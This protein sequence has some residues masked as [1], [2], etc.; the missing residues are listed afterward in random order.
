[1]GLDFDFN[2]VVSAIV[3]CVKPISIRELYAQLLSI[4][5][6]WELTQGGHQASANVARQGRG[7]GLGLSGR[8]G[9][10]RGHGRRRGGGGRGG[11]YSGSNSSGKKEKIPCQVC[12]KV[13]HLALDCWH[14]FDE[15]YTF[16][17]KSAST[18]VNNYGVDTNWYSDSATTDHITR[19]LDKLTTKDKYKENDQI[20][21]ANGTCMD[22]CN[23]GHVVINTPSRTLHLNNVLHLPN[24]SKKSNICP[25]FL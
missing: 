2:P 16:D 18:T 24:A 14:R 7:G 6:R 9:M 3:A 20:L 1:V 10:M 12:D 11:Y 17:N 8:G 22:I 21:A 13:G 19:E 4:E 15:T 23:I 5:A 25:S